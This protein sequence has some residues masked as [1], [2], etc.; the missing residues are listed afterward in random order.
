MKKII[1]SLGAILGVTAT[2][3]SLSS[4]GDSKATLKDLDG[5]DLVVEKTKDEE[6]VSKALVAVANSYSN[7][8]KNIYS[9]GVDIKNATETNMNYN[10]TTIESS[11]EVSGVAKLTIGKNNYVD[12]KDKILNNTLTD[13]D[14]ANAKESL[15]SNIDFEAELNSKT[16]SKAVVD[17]EKLK[18]YY[19]EMGINVSNISLTDQETKIDVDIN[20]KAFLD[21][22]DLYAEADSKSGSVVTS[23]TNE[24]KQDIVVKDIF[25][26][27]PVAE[28]STALNTFKS[29]SLF[30]M[31]F[32]YANVSFDTSILTS[33][34]F[35]DSEAYTMIKAYVKELE[36]EIT[37]TANNEITFD[38]KVKG[39]SFKAIENMFINLIG[40]DYASS[41]QVIDFEGIDDDQE[42]GN[43]SLTYSVETGFV[44]K[45]STK[46][47]LGSCTSTLD[48][49]EISKYK[50]SA[51]TSY[52]YNDDVKFNLNK[53][54]SKT[55]NETDLSTIIGS[56]I[57]SLGN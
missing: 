52:I 20:L 50:T 5:N 46:V 24:T 56:I 18:D 25:D 51:E 33:A 41:S 38:A 12:Y 37:N 21:N 39:N 36:I 44:K 47:D 3:L 29:S 7:N 54:S 22:G 45:V 15:K 31:I 2:A 35:Y 14:I 34:E 8:A 1:L 16:N 32:E 30:D 6:A 4:C 55:Y 43:F 27:I 53:D 17:A 13:D 57:S 28:V 9:I 26:S 10:Y 19:R 11:S 48:S 40:N 42:I 49:V 23:T